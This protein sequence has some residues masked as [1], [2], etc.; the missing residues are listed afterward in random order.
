MKEAKFSISLTFLL[1][2]TVNSGT[3]TSKWLQDGGLEA[4]A[5]KEADD[6]NVADGGETEDRELL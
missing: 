4:T 5:E 2:F 3:R 1:A 6:G